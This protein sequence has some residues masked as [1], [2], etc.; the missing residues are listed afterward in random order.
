MDGNLLVSFHFLRKQTQNYA[1]TKKWPQQ[2]LKVTARQNRNKWNHFQ[3]K[4]KL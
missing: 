2:D 4:I 3:E 1:L